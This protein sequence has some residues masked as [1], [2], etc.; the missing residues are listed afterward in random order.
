CLRTL[1]RVLG[2]RGQCL[3]H[4]TGRGPGRGSRRA[5]DRRARRAARPARPER[6]HLERR[7]PRRAGHR[8]RIRPH[9]GPPMTLKRRA[10]LAAS[11]FTTL[12]GAMP[13]AIANVLGYPRALQGPMLGAPGPGHLSVW[14]RASGAFEVTLEVA[15]DRDFGSIVSRGSGFARAE[16]HCCVVLRAE[17]LAPDTEYWYRLRYAGQADRYQW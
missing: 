1:G 17:G 7:D 15:T 14:V 12:L 10:F 11:A 4:G 16:D 8:T 5:R 6:L 9:A 2:A 13:R 3:G